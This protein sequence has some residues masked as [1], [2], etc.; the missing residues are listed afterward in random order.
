MNKSSS[1]FMSL[2]A[3]V[4]SI[5]ALCLCLFCCHKKTNGVEE[6][7][8]A[9]PEM[10]IEA[11]QAYEQN[12]R[13]QA[14]A[15]AKK[16]VEARINDLNN[17]ATTPFVG[18]K[19]AK[20]TVVEFFDYSCG[21]CHRLFPELKAVVEA[22][23]NVKFVFKP[24]TFLGDVSVA[25]AKASLAAAK[26]GKFIEMH[27]ALF[28]AN[29][30]LT[31]EKIRAIAQE[32]G[33]DMSKFDADIASDDVATILK[34]A[35]ELANAIQVNGVPA[36]FINGGLLQTLDGKDIQAAINANK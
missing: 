26:Q 33:L 34:N 21:Y 18:P 3:L 35:S 11:I 27:N 25:A 4:L 24:L 2:A 19:D 16:L 9:K 13:E 7:L 6:A 36:L 23:P 31:Q 5:A 15:E 14:Q 10:V 29:D 17:D 32:Q 20:I 30:R 1:F 28:G 22:N 8:K 12:A